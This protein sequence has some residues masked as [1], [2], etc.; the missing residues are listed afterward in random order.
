MGLVV[1]PCAGGQHGAPG[2]LARRCAPRHGRS[3]PAGGF[4][5]RAQDICSEDEIHSVVEAMLSTGLHA[6]GWTWISFDDCWEAAERDA[7]GDLMAD[8]GR[9]PSGMAALVEY[10]HAANFSVQIYTRCGGVMGCVCWRH[11]LTGGAGSLGRTTCRHSL[12]GSYGHETQVRGHCCATWCGP[13]DRVP[14][15]D[16][17][18][19]DAAWFAR[20]GADGMKGDWCG[21]RRG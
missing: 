19:Q 1:Y 15:P 16:Y 4:Q 18:N 11:A 10:I 21:G 2:G 14:A 17:S 9:F 3:L 6:A 8:P 20:I 7:S 13:R 12:P 5:A